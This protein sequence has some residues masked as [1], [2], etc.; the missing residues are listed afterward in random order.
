LIA[1][2]GIGSGIFCVIF[3]GIGI[4]EIC[5]KKQT[6]RK[7]K[8]YA[9]EIK[10][11]AKQH[12]AAQKAKEADTLAVPGTGDLNNSFNSSGTTSSGTSARKSADVTQKRASL[13]GTKPT[14]VTAL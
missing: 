12:R 6:E 13:A 11:R 4:L 1:G 10:R 14:E 5:L 8:R 9:E 7:A 3:F 2:V